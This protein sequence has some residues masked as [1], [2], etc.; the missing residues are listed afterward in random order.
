MN[1]FLNILLSFVSSFLLLVP[2]FSAW[3][4][5][6]RKAKEYEEQR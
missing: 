6:K 5:I 2:V 1:I 3:Y 4:Y